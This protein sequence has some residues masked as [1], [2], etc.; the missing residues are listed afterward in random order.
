MIDPQDIV[1]YMNTLIEHDE[2][3]I[4]WM[5]R[6]RYPCSEALTETAAHVHHNEED[7]FSIGLLHCDER[8]HAQ[9]GCDC[10]CV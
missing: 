4:D 2:P 9:R 7:G 6:G 3:V 10:C 5:I 1:D 8:I